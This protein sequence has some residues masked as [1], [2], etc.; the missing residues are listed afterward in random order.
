M[1]ILPDLAGPGGAVAVAEKLV[2]SLRDPLPVAG[3]ELVVTCS[4]GVALFPDDGQDSAAL[5]KAAD[6][7]LYVVKRRGRDGYAI[8]AR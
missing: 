5:Q 1:V 3:R 8:R 4:I 7:Q 6:D 2:H